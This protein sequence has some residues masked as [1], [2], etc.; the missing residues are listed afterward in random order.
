MSADVGNPRAVP[1]IDL[2]LTD[3]AGEQLEE[4]SERTGLSV[5]EL[6][7]RGM[8][9]QQVLEAAWARGDRVLLERN[10]RLHLVEPSDARERREA[11]LQRWA[12]VLG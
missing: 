4:L 7:A 3:E 2:N 8:A 10:G 1:T 5:S 6:V 11:R 9:R 12:Q